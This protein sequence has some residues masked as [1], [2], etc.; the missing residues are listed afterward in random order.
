MFSIT[1]SLHGREVKQGPELE[2]A[3]KTIMTDK[4]IDAVVVDLKE[5][6]NDAIAILNLFYS[7]F[8]M[9]EFRKS[10]NLKEMTRRLNDSLFEELTKSA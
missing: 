6:S 4:F 10:K 9:E 1:A 3:K 8:A 2:L 5:L 7:C